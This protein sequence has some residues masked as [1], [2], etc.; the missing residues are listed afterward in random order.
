MNCEVTYPS[1]KWPGNHVQCL[2]EAV[3]HL[4]ILVGPKDAATELWQ[5]NVCESHRLDASNDLDVW[6]LE[7][8]VNPPHDHSA[9]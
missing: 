3:K 6:T 2:N 8:E 1:E 9:N 4:T 7:E 5:G